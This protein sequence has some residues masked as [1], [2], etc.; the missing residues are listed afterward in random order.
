MEINFGQLQALLVQYGT[1]LIG[2]FVVFVIGWWII[3][4][5]ARGLNKFLAKRNIDATLRPFLVSVFEAALKAMLVISVAG[6]LGIETTSF[7]AILGAAGLAVG[8]AL[9]GSLANF[10]GGVLILIFKPFKLGDYIVSQGFEGFVDE[11]N[12]F[13]T[14]LRSHDNKKVILPNGT[15]SNN[16]LTNVTTMGSL[17]ITTPAAIANIADIAAARE[18]MLSAAAVDPRVRRDPAPVVLVSSLRDNGCDLI[19][20][21]WCASGDAIDVGFALTEGVKKALSQ[22]NIAGPIQERHLI[23]R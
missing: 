23:T 18:A 6:I 10:A 21:T 9:Q 4:S 22:K 16:P 8:L 17:R 5:V 3:G 15:L 13:T 7:V 1:K 11:L 14:T 2:A 20:N 12:I 19:M